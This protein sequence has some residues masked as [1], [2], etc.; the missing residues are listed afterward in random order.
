MTSFQALLLRIAN[1]YSGFMEPDPEA[2]IVDMQTESGSKINSTT[3]KRKQKQNP[4]HGPVFV[5]LEF[6]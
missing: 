1:P 3:A 5:D 4:R 2:T 6:E